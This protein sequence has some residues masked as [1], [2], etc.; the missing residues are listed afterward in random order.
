MFRPVT[1]SIAFVS[2]LCAVASAGPLHP[3]QGPITSTMKSLDAIEPRV[4]VNDLPGD[5]GAVV[6]IDQ[7]GQYFLRADIVGGVGQHGIRVTAQGDVSIDLNGFDL[8]GVPGSLHGIDMDFG[9]SV[10]NTRLEVRCPDGTCRSRISGW[11]TGVHTHGVV[12]CV[13]TALAVEDCGGN[14]LNHLHAE[15]VI[16]RDI[17]TRNCLGHGTLV[18]PPSAPVRSNGVTNRFRA[19]RAFSNGGSG[20]S[21]GARADSYEIDFEDC[22]ACGN[23]GDGVRIDE[24]GSNQTGAGGGGRV[25]LQGVTVRDS[26]ADGIHVSIPCASPTVVSASS[27]ACISNVGD[28]MEIDAVGAAVPHFGATCTIQKSEFSS[29]AGN[30]VRS[31]NPLHTE[32]STYSENAL[33]GI[34]D[35]FAAR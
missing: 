17:A 28:G 15:G 35:P 13:C 34:S 29:N 16:H 26:G 27:V 3:P 22:Y 31:E 7:P 8:L 33:Y 12:I 30:G 5:E 1:A 6:I 19:C 9:T 25:A 18:S 23:I 21:I 10:A 32:S 14:G 24:D 20:W 2:L 4:C 11:D